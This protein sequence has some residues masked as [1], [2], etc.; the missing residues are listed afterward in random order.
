MFFNLSYSEPQL[1]I[2]RGQLTDEPKQKSPRVLV[3][4]NSYTKE[5]LDDQPK[6]DTNY[7]YDSD[8]SQRYGEFSAINISDG[9][10][11]KIIF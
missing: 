11:S 1:D 2:P 4:P 10:K 7:P 6:S 5:K 9:L 3:L 8:R